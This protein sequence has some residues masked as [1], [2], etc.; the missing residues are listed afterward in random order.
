MISKLFSKKA[1]LILTAA[2]LA[3]AACACGRAANT[4]EDTV[5][6]NGEYINAELHVELGDITGEEIRPLHGINNGPR[7]DYENGEFRSDASLL[8]K[9]AGIPY[10]RTHD[11]EYPYG[12]DVFVDIHCVFPDPEADPAKESSYHFNETDEYI[13]SVIDSGAEVFFRLGE[14]IDHSGNALYIGAP[15]D[16]YKWAEICAGI[17]AHYNHGFAD[18]YEYGITYFEIWNEPENAAMWTGSSEEFYELYKI[19]S[20]YLK[21]C[22]PYIRIGGYGAAE[23]RDEF[24]EGFLK[25]ISEGERAPLDFF[26]WHYYN[27][28]IDGYAYNTDLIRQTLNRYGYEDTEIILDEWAY[29]TGFSIKDI[30]SS[31]ELMS[32]EI[33]ASYTASSMIAM[34]NAG[35]DKAMYYDAAFLGGFCILYEREQGG[36]LSKL[37]AYNAFYYF[38]KL[39]QLKNRLDIT[40]GTEDLLLLGAG[41]GQNAAIL[42]S[43][44]GQEEKNRYELSISFSGEQIPSKARI[45]VTDGEYPLGNISEQELSDDSLQIKIEP[46]SITLIELGDL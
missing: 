17:V 15:E 9:E 10:V 19:A 42:I 25:Y 43:S 30:Q 7:F 35:I 46:Y 31:Y 1:G 33:G 14:S 21:D 16:P 29:S 36:E 22:F 34:Q 40:A 24:M 13:K 32:T 5:S 20:G 6:E 2:I 8:F 45:Y 12:K 44:F 27:Q 37:P 3:L 23:P 41:D 26:S 39:Y 18:G 4:D 38:N 28:G 11:T